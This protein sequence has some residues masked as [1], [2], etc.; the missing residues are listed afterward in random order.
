MHNAAS[1]WN[2]GFI[3]PACNRRAL[4]PDKSGVPMAVSRG[5]PQHLHFKTWLPLRFG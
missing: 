2:A 1:A 3:R 4:L 5:T